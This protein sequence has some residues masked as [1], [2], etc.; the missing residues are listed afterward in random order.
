VLASGRNSA[1]CTSPS[2]LRKKLAHAHIARARLWQWQ[3]AAKTP[4]G[5]CGAG[6]N[7]RP[8]ATLGR[9]DRPGAAS[10]SEQPGERNQKDSTGAEAREGQRDPSGALPWF[11]WYADQD[12]I[13]KVLLRHMG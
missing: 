3:P 5:K 8:V 7:A 9:R 10:L 1:G 2:W 12:W 6:A 11:E 4:P 13:T